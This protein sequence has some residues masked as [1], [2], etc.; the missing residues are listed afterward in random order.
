[1]WG[2]DAYPTTRAVDN[3]VLKLRK[4]FERKDGPRYFH[5]IYGAGYRFTPTPEEIDP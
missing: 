3:L 2:Y 5:T 4:R 1:V